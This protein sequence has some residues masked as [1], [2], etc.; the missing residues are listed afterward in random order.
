MALQDYIKN[1]GKK[2]EKLIKTGTITKHVTW[3]GVRSGE[4]SKINNSLID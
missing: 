3:K 2:S 1:K 4:F